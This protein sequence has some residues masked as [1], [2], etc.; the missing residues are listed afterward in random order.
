[1]K[2]TTCGRRRSGAAAC[3]IVALAVIAML[4]LSGCATKVQTIEVPVAVSCVKERPA[5][6]EFRTD[7]EIVALDDY[8]AVYALRAERTKAAKYIGELE[9]VVTVCEGAPSVV[10]VPK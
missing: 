5:R 6:P 9:D 3:F 10:S 2:I 1:M 8:R 4:V 7:A